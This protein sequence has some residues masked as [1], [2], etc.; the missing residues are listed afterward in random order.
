MSKRVAIVA[1]LTLTLAS[2]AWAGMVF[3]STTTVE[4]G[5]GAQQQASKVKGWA[6]GDRGKVEF[7][8]SGNPM[9]AVG[10]FLI[11]RD[12]GKEVFLVN[13]KD[14]TYAKWDM[15]GMMQMA[16]GAMKMMNMKFSDPVVEKLGEELDGLVANVPTIHYRFRTSYSMSMNFMGMKSSS[17]VVKEEEIWSAPKLVEMALGIWFRK[18]PPKFGDPSLDNLVKAEMDKIQGYPLKRVWVQTS[19]NEKGKTEVTKMTMETTSLEMAL[20]PASTFEIPAGYTETNLFGG[21]G[22]EGEDGENPFAKMMGGKK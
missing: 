6:D 5:K 8:E 17:K 18:T 4:G 19:V 11:T 7:I 22:G 9:L 13:P 1:V 14:K 3:T 20:V 16:G 21:K 15:E 10:N 2:G 12:G